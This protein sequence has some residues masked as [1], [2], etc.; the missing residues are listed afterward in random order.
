MNY[1]V[2]IEDDQISNDSGDGSRPWE[3]E[4]IEKLIVDGKY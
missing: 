2:E 3:D 1:I 4:G